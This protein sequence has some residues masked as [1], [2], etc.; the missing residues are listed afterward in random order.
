V[1]GA[2]ARGASLLGL[3]EARDAAVG[4]GRILVDGTVGS[5]VVV[6]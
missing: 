2:H 6:L 4:D 1:D 5:P 3:A